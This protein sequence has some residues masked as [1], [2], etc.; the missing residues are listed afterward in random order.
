M[1]ST[2]ID[3]YA[4]QILLQLYQ[5]KSGDDKPAPRRP[6]VWAVLSP[7]E[8]AAL[9]TLIDAWVDSYNRIDAV[10]E[11]ELVPPCWPA[12]FGLATKL[13]VM[14]W[15]YYAA[16]RDPGATIIAATEYHLRYLPAFR[17]SVERML[18]RDPAACR[19][20]Q[21]PDTWRK[22]IDEALDSWQHSTPDAHHDEDAVATLTQ[23]GFGF[24]T[25]NTG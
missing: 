21:H 23:L 14:T 11:H 8:T 17:T 9:G 24:P 19:A 15:L 13:P 22:S 7:T 4:W 1:T 3:P 6:W 2:S 16:H 12:H 5:Q 10:N 25:R 20:G 18:G